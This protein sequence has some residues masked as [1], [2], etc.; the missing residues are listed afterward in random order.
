MRGLTIATVLLL[1]G[2]AS[3]PPQEDAEGTLRSV[4]EQQRQMVAA[5]NVAGLERLA[6]PNLRIN[7]PTGRVLTRDQFLS[8][9]RSGQIG[10]EQFDRIAEMVIITGDQAVVMGRETFTPTAQSELGRTYGAV[11]LQRRYTNVYVRE[12]GRWR[13]V[14]RHANVVQQR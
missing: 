6:H 11:P 8:M 2:C 5:A 10:A 3:V 9:M 13:W 4:D 14:A 12:A 7:A 1:L